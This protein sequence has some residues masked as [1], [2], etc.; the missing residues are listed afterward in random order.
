MNLTIKEQKLYNTKFVKAIPIL[1]PGTYY[2]KD[3]FDPGPS[4]PRIA[5]K[6]YEDVVDG[7]FNN[8]SLVGTRSCEGYIVV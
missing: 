7:R 6:F 5:R 8:V 2:I 3:F 1:I 4:V